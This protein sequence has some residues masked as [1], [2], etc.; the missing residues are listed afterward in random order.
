MKR[1]KKSR[2]LNTK[3][4]RNIGSDRESEVTAVILTS[5]TKGKGKIKANKSCAK[6]DQNKSHNERQGGRQVERPEKQNHK[7][8]RHGH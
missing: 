3:M 1:L 8:R 5:R 7:H 2:I 4:A 6:S